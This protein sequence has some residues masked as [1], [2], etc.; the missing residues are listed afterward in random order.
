MTARELGR[1]AQS[2]QGKGTQSKL[3]RPSTFRLHQTV[4]APHCSCH[5]F[6]IV[7]AVPSGLRG[8]IAHAKICTPCGI[9]SGSE[10]S[11]QRLSHSGVHDRW[12]SRPSLRSPLSSCL[13]S[14]PAEPMM[15]R[16][17][18]PAARH[19]SWMGE[20]PREKLPAAEQWSQHVP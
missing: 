7:D 2:S 14:F 16:E 9:P 12:S 1:A 19:G 4:F 20:M 10:C 5:I 11:F 6:L 13:S 17:K 3:C 18:L 15:P 8:S